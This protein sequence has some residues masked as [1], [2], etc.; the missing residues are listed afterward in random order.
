MPKPNTRFLRHII[1]GTDHHNKTLLAKEAAESQARLKDLE[2]TSEKKRLKTNPTA[3]D[4]GRR[5]MGDIQAILGGT[6][7]RRVREDKKDESKTDKDDEKEKSNERR[8]HRE[9]ERSKER[10]GK[11]ERSRSRDRDRRSRRRDDDHKSSRRRDDSRDAHRSR[12]HSDS[13][14]HGRDRDRDRSRSPR[15]KSRDRRRSKERSEHRRRSRSRDETR[16][17]RTRDSKS[18]AQSD[19]DPLDEIIGPAPA[20]KLRGRG[21]AGFSSGIDRRFSESYDPK[22]DSGMDD[23]QPEASSGWDNAVEEFRDRQ[24]SRANQEERL[25]SAGF[26]DGQIRMASETDEVLKDDFKWSK[27]GEKKAWDN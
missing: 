20:P 26:T 25:R 15:R 22:L 2:R 1:K 16:S 27:S 7:R 9:R 3:R 14:R 17:R 19:S 8:S 12:R 13:K 21:A 11:K 18:E 24:K 10:D 5:H 6:K 4:I 23:E